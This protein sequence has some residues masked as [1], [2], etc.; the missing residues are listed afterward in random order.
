MTSEGFGE[1]LEGDFDKKKNIYP[2]LAAEIFNLKL[3][4]VIVIYCIILCMILLF[5]LARP[6]V[7]DMID[8]KEYSGSDT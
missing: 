8:V 3:D 5:G 6:V 2:Y 7:S 4:T 1:V